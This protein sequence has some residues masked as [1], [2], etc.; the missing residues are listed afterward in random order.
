MKT[1]YIMLLVAVAMWSYNIGTLYNV[2]ETNMP[3]VTAVELIQPSQ[4]Q[5][6]VTDKPNGTNVNPQLT[7]DGKTLQ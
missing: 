6:E 1:L 2:L 3:T 4:P 7:V 5:L